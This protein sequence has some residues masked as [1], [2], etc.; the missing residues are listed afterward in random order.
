MRELVA[1]YK[2]LFGSAGVIVTLLWLVLIAFFGPVFVV[3]GS[4]PVLGP[5]GFSLILIG[6]GY[7]MWRLAADGFKERANGRGQV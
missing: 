6:N 5:V 4:T 1:W 2:I 3:L 7:G